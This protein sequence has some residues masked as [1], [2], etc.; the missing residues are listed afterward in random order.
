M[1]WCRSFNPLGFSLWGHIHEQ[2]L[3]QHHEVLTTQVLIPASNKSVPLRSPIALN[4]QVF[5]TVLC[6]TLILRSVFHLGIKPQVILQASL[7]NF[8]VFH[9]YML[10]NCPL[11]CTHELLPAPLKH[12]VAGVMTDLECAI[13]AEY[14]VTQIKIPD[15]DGWLAY[16]NP[17][18]GFN[19]LHQIS[20]VLLQLISREI[21]C[22]HHQRHYLGLTTQPFNWWLIHCLV[23]LIKILQN[24]IRYHFSSVLSE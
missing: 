19:N 6:T 21:H 10:P 7:V 23:A 22:K 16:F 13:Q 1:T 17:S 14:G 18:V 11:I 24:L 5:Q 12:C 8:R 3:L 9:N 20:T 15:K 4:I 2:L